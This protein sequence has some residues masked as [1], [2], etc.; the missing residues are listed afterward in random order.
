MSDI[1]TWLMWILVFSW[2]L[3]I[4]M[5]VILYAGLSF[6]WV[7][8]VLLPTLVQ[9]H[10]FYSFYSSTLL[11]FEHFDIACTHSESIYNMSPYKFHI[12]NTDKPLP[13]CQD[14]YP[15]TTLVF[16]FIKYDL[17]KCYVCFKNLSPYKIS[18]HYSWMALVLFP[19]HKVT[20]SPSRWLGAEKYQDWGVIFI[21]TAAEIG[22]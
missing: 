22:Q 5:G 9:L 19:P 4:V 6:I 2:K 16:I 1:K 15:G 7:N 10:K 12:T 11:A 21:S 17:N 20:R 3:K 13:S 8:T 14:F 18:T